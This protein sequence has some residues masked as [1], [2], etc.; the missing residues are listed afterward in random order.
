MY[1]VTDKFK[2]CL[3]TCS[4]FMVNLDEATQDQLEHLFHSGHKGVEFVGKKPKNK[5]VDNLS[6]ETELNTNE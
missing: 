2:G 6:K 1:K 5:V 3:V 4:K